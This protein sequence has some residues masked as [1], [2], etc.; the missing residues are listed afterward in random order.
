VRL[1]RPPYGAHDAR[2]DDVVRREGLVQVLWNVDSRDSLGASRSQ[3]FENV[4]A[5][6]RPGA[7]ILL[8]EVK[9]ETVRALPAIVAELRKRGLRSVSIP[10]L[11]R[12]DPPSAA[13]LKAGFSGCLPGWRG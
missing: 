13:R 5:G 12:L 4:R 10:E 3:I 6:L 11:L 7:I 9:G 8:H 2:V 1:F